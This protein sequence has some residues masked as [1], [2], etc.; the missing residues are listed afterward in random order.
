MACLGCLCPLGAHHGPPL[1]ARVRPSPVENRWHVSGPEGSQ[2]A[3]EPQKTRRKKIF[4]LK[5][6]TCKNPFSSGTRNGQWFLEEIL[7]QS[8]VIWGRDPA[9]MRP[10]LIHLSISA[11]MAINVEMDCNQQQHHIQPLLFTKSGQYPQL[12]KPLDKS[13]T[14]SS[15]CLNA[16]GKQSCFSPGKG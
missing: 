4:L 8:L 13:L 12:P 9:P 11:P 1:P 5:S 6:S 14:S 7:I 15:S 10:S 2:K 16:L 3:T